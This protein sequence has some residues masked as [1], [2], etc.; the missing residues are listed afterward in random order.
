[1]EY[2]KISEII[3]DLEISDLPEGDIPLEAIVIIKA[4]NEDGKPIWHIKWTKELYLVEMCGAL[5][6]FSLSC[7]ADFL[8]TLREV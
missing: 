8:D 5:R 6:G 4:L 1:M 7:E 2:K 3:G